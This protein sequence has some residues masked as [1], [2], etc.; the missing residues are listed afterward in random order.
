M[1]PTINTTSRIEPHKIVSKETMPVTTMLLANTDHMIPF[2]LLN[3]GISAISFGFTLVPDQ[4]CI[5]S[6]RTK[7]HIAMHHNIAEQNQVM[8]AKMMF[9][10]SIATIPLF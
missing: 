9:S 10:N 4:R 7:T 2:A 3:A 1:L 8:H 5:G 6:F